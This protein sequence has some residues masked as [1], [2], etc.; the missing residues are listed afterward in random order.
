M[1][2]TVN[3]MCGPEPAGDTGGKASLWLGTGRGT[4]AAGT[5]SDR[6]KRGRCRANRDVL[7]FSPTSGVPHAAYRSGLVWRASAGPGSAAWSEG[8][9]RTQSQRSHL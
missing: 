3:A 1:W 7:E 2:L 9:D 4:P 5:A 6:G 8:T